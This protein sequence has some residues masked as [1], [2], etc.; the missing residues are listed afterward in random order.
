MNM[1]QVFVFLK[2]F[3]ANSTFKN[4]FTSIGNNLLD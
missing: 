4:K 3:C 2:F 1:R